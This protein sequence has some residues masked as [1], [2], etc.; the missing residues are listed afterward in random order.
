LLQGSLPA[1][2][3]LEASAPATP[4]VV[5]GN[6]TQ[7]HQVV[8]NLCSNAIQAMRTRGLLRVTLET[9]EL[10]TERALSHGTLARGDYLR[11]IVEDSGS[12]MDEATLA[13][14][15]EPFFTTKEVGQ[16][17]G[18]GLSLVYA[19]IVQWGGAIDVKSAREQGSTFTTYL[20]RLGVAPDLA[21]PGSI[22]LSDTL[23][24]EYDL[25][26]VGDYARPDVAVQV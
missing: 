14:L 9:E 5:I 1:G 17:T 15:F 21:T 18:L 10:S 4:L 7:L 3:R 23:R 13:R 8:M 24:G 26:V 22:D 16:G 19:I 6:A 25:N 11:L 20:P 12:G 2:I